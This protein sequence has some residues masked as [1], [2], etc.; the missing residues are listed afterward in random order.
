MES[1]H[2]LIVA[3]SCYSGTLTRK[4]YTNLDSK[5]NRDRYLDKMLKRTSRTLLAS[6][7]NEPVADSGRNGHS[8]FAEAFIEGLQ[9]MDIVT[10]TAE[11]L[12]YTSIKE[13]VAGKA[14]QI[15]E[16]N[17]IRNSGHDGGDFI[18]RR[19]Q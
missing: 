14:E 5:Q 4:A 2:I 13:R 3:D 7:G 10:F 11:E 17:T 6:G 19:V 8:V 18:F 1:N 9:E 15:P 12:F 16:Y